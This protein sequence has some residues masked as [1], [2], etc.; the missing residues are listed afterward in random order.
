M[1]AMPGD[2]QVDHCQSQSQ[3]ECY[4]CRIGDGKSSVVDIGV[5]CKGSKEE[6]TEPEKV[7]FRFNGTFYIFSDD[8]LINVCFGEPVTTTEDSFNDGEQPEKA[9][10]LAVHLDEPECSE[11]KPAPTTGGDSSDVSS[12]GDAG[13]E[14]RGDEDGGRRR[15][16]GDGRKGQSSTQGEEE[17]LKE[18]EEAMKDTDEKVEGNEKDAEEKVEEDYREEKDE[19]KEQQQENLN[20]P[21]Y[22]S[23]CLKAVME[24]LRDP[25][26]GVCNQ[27][28]EFTRR[29]DSF[30]KHLRQCHLGRTACEDCL[31][32]LHAFEYLVSSTPD[33]FP[34]YKDYK[35]ARNKEERYLTILK[36]LLKNLP[37]KKLQM[38]A[39]CEDLKGM[40]FSSGQ[41]ARPKKK[42]KEAESSNKAMAMETT[43]SPDIDPVGNGIFP[44]PR[45][46]H[47]LNRRPAGV[48]YGDQE[49]CRNKICDWNHNHDA[50]D[51]EINDGVIFNK[52]RFSLFNN[53]NM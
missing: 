19:D 48:I 7:H 31:L 36:W 39:C 37:E 5:K 3:E 42:F 44:G 24:N 17:E 22:I 13:D 11:K 38:E 20:S 15:G 40:R 23:K 51:G 33:A 29:G 6:F 50:T 43:P 32:I 18:E 14:R 12:S 26:N 10:E 49:T 9:S 47:V 28:T 8:N 27:Q 53:N 30:L 25:K 45:G 16:D 34:F 21:A 35:R 4:D 41:G 2:Q 1:P 52:V 46:G